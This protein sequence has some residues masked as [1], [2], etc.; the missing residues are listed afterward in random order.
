MNLLAV[1]ADVILVSSYELNLIES[2]GDQASW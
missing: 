1:E 2:A